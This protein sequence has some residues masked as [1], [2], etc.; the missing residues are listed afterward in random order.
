LCTALWVY[1][2]LQTG[3]H[4]L[5]AGVVTLKPYD[6]DRS[7]GLRPVGALA[8]TGFWMLF[9]TVAPLVVTGS[10]DRATVLVGVAVLAV[11][12][13]M[14]FLSLRRLHRHMEAVKNQ[15]LAHARE[16]YQQ[17]YRPLGEKPTLAVLDANANLLRAAGDLE[18][19]A[20]R[21]Q[22]WPFDEGTFARVVTIASSVVA[23]II[24]RLLLA[25]TG[26]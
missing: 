21:I 20:E 4:R 2:A 25:P 3:L 23:A 9:G 7:L 18:Q 16:L 1:L 12:V 14:F 17:A 24:T 15:G 22:A 19:R 6:G 10:S 26:L 13:A 5:G 11:G 8:F